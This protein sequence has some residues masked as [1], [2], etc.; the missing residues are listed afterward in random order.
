M[1]L[2]RQ[3]CTRLVIEFRNFVVKVPNFTY[4]W[5]HF[6]CGLVANINEARTWKWHERKDLLCP[7]L[8]AS[9]GG[10]FLVMR[11]VRVLTID[12]Y[13]AAN[14][15]DHFTHFPGDNKANSYG[16]LDNKIVKIDYGQ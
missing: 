15:E 4:S 1:K 12:E 3:G 7:I 5:L 9:W 6:L 11:K 14:L 16:Y 10:W 8:W 13:A 2:N